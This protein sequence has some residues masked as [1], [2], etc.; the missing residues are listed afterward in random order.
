VLESDGKPLS[1]ANLSTIAVEPAPNSP[2]H[3]VNSVS[4]DGRTGRFLITPVPLGGKYRIVAS[5]SE[6]G[7]NARTISDLLTIDAKQPIH[8]VTLKLPPGQTLAGQVVDRDG[9]PVAGAGLSLDWASPYSH[10]FSGGTQNTDAEG[11]FDFQRVNGDLPGELSVHVR[12]TQRHPGKQVAVKVDFGR[13]MRI[14]LEEGQSVSGVVIDSET[15]RAI[16][17]ARISAGPVDWPAGSYRGTVSTVADVQ[18]RFRF[19]NLEKRTYWLRVEGAYSPGTIVRKLP[20]GST[21]YTY[22]QGSNWPK[23]T[24]P[25]IERIELRVMMPE[26]RQ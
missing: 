7:N 11:R 26:R 14:V 10:G 12:P 8:E 17:A 16:A 6:T 13:P 21:Q 22:P 19:D 18:G 24:A 4:S 20:N 2:A 5:H 9:R 23:I 1:H 25:R 3:P 15:G